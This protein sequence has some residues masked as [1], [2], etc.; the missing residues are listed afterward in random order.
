MKELLEN[1]VKCSYMH[2]NTV[3]SCN[4]FR[5]SAMIES[6]CM[7]RW[8]ENM[9]GFAGQMAKLKMQFLNNV[10]RE[11]IVSEDPIKKLRKSL[12]HIYV[13]LIVYVFGICFAFVF[14]VAQSLC[15]LSK[16]A[17][18]NPISNLVYKTISKIS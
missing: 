10:V 15:F 12:E 3:F 9:A 6:G 7:Q 13:A 2:D 8:L 4:S 17:S 16:K 18:I 1:A 14:F 5:V 11:E